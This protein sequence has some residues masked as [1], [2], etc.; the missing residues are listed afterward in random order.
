MLKCLCA[1]FA[2]T[3]LAIGGSGAAQAGD[4][5]TIYAGLYTCMT[6]NF[7]YSGGVALYTDNRYAYSY[8]VNGNPPRSL[9]RP[10][11]GRIRIAGARIAFIGGP[12]GKF[13]AVIKTPK[14]MAVYR[15]GER[16]PYTWC[17]FRRGV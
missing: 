16:Y 14:K 3:V 7:T 17:T 11:W 8:S 12:W 15:K 10:G 9:R 2:L 5:A 1:V 13:Y 6:S 4:Q